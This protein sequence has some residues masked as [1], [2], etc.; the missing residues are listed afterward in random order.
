VTP[1]WINTYVSAIANGGTLNKPQVANR[2]IDQNKKT[3][4]IKNPTELGKLPFSADSIRE[5]QLG[6]RETVRTGTARS[7]QDLP[8][9]AAAKTGT[10]EVIKGHSINALFTTYAPFDNPEIT[11]TVLVEGSA[12]NEGYAINIAHNFMRWYFNQGVTNPEP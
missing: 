3:L 10:A 2:V 1:L 7:L 9:Q 5:V 8:V 12:T 6:M 11:M 4:E